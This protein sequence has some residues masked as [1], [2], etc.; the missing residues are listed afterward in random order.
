M[1]A[2]AHA[3]RYPDSV[4]HLVLIVTA[5]HGGF[6]ARAQQIVEQ[7]GTPEQQA[8]CQKLWAGAIWSADEMRHFYAV[9]GPMY[10]RSHDPAA[11]EAGRHRTIH[12]P[13][14]LNRA[15]GPDGFLRKYDLRPEL[16]RITAPTL[17]LGGRHDWICAPEFSEEIARLIPGADLR[18]FERSSHS[19]RADEPQAMVDAI[20]GFVVYRWP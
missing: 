19:I 16:S 4:S 10:S 8:V 6:I 13:E 5:A 11:A 9:M 1:V 20:L 17:V 14:P 2:M 12:S 18:I 3:A 15:V 7:C